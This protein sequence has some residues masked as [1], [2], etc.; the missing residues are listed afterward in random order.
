MPS[1]FDAMSLIML[2]VDMV[3]ILAA[4]NLKRPKRESQE[5]AWGEEMLPDDSSRN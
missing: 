4:L 1:N 5:V 2:V 3:V